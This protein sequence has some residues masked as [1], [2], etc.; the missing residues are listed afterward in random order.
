MQNYGLGDSLNV[1]RVNAPNTQY[2]P[3]VNYPNGGFNI[4]GMKGRSTPSLGNGRFLHTQSDPNK[5]LYTKVI[6][7]FP[8]GALDL[9][10]GTLVFTEID[11]DPTIINKNL[12]DKHPNACVCYTLKQMRELRLFGIG[13]FNKRI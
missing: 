13:K 9:V 3:G 11:E 5:P 1:R 7:F 12:L 10:E 8:L 6:G 4:R 2:R